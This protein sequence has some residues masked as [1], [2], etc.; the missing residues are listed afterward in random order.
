MIEI[1]NVKITKADRA[2]IVYKKSEVDG[3]TSEVTENH[4]SK[5]HEDFKNA[6]A[7][8]AVHFGV[9]TGYIKSSDVKDPALY[10]KDVDSFHVSGYS[11]GG[12]DEDQGIVIKGYRILPG[13][14]KAV[15][16]NSPFTRFNEGDETRYKHMDHLINL[17]ENARDEATKYLGGKFAPEPQLALELNEKDKIDEASQ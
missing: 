4:H 8:L 14:G 9:L 12:E 6:L 5:V 3:A 2:V 10:G 7:Q 15:I 11:I 1:K 17:I 16:L 13:S